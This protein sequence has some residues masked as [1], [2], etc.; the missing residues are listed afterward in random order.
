M[1]EQKK[2]KKKHKRGIDINDKSKWGHRFEI[3]NRAQ[4]VR[5]FFPTKAVPKK[6]NKPENG[7]Q[8]KASKQK[9]KAEPR[10]QKKRKLEMNP[11]NIAREIVEDLVESAL[12]NNIELKLEETK[13]EKTIASSNLI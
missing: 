9:T 8:D 11:Y 12:G 13:P 2:S 10:P 3:R 5:E 4:V 6:R 7:E 1:K